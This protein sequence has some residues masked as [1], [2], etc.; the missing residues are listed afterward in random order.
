MRNRVQTVAEAAG[1]DMAD[2]IRGALEINL[3]HMELQL[4]LTSL[5]DYEEEELVAAGL[6]AVLEDQK[7]RR[8]HEEAEEM[9]AALKEDRTVG[10]AWG[11]PLPKTEPSA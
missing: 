2:I 3:I 1:C 7:R 9:R 4:R 5:D 11:T 8:M 10:L 6:G